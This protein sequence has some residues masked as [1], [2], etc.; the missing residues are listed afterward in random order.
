MNDRVLVTGA[1]GWLGT[2][3]VQRLIAQGDSVTCYVHPEEEASELPKACRIA[4]GDVRDAGGLAEAASETD[5][6]VHLAAVIHTT[7]TRDYD[8]INVGGTR[9]ALDAAVRAG[10]KRFVFMSSNAA[11][12]SLHGGLID[13][14]GPMRPV[15]AYGRSKARGENLVRQYEGKL[16]AT[17]IRAPMF[18]GPGQPHRMTRLMRMVQHGRPPVF[19]RGENLRSMAYLDNLVDAMMLVLKNEKSRGQVYWIA[20]ARPYST[21][22]VLE[23]IARVLDVPL[24]PLYLPAIIARGCE[25]ADQIL[26]RCGYHSLNLHIVGESTHWIACACEKARRELGYEPSVSLEEGLRRAVDW[27]RHRGL[28][29]DSA[30]S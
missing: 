28:I 14:S 11:Q 5:V 4:R 17:I 10:V 12:G 3:F 19:G 1:P 27:C 26:E 7:W 16:S 20:D 8:R 6:V 15:S 22:E 24:R 30:K 2:R 21:I 23:T 18:Y 29:G 25:L 9:N 13:E